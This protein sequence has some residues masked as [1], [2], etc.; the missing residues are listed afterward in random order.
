MPDAE[1]KPYNDAITQATPQAKAAAIEAYL[2][3]FPSRHVGQQEYT[4]E[5]LTIAYAGT[6]DSAKTIAAAHR[7]LQLNRTICARSSLKHFSQGRRGCDHRPAAQISAV[8]VAAGYAQR[9]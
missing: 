9:A 7:V 1:Y 4:L 8:D 5:Q 2:T 3:A 6:N